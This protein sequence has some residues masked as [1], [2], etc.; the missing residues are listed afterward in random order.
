MST[1]VSD[2]RVDAPEWTRSRVSLSMMSRAL[3]AHS[4]GSITALLALPKS[5]FLSGKLR[6]APLFGRS[7]QNVIF[8]LR[9]GDVLG[10]RL[11][12]RTRATWRR[13][14]GRYDVRFGRP[15]ARREKGETLMDLAR[16]YGVS[17]REQCPARLQLAGILH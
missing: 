12:Q 5:K 17:R 16:S 14:A 1:S 9:L 10:A 2:L 8:P 15:L 4:P 6:N 13:C 7:R 3:R 11:S